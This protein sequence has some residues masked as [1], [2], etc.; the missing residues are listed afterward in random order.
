[1]KELFLARP[2]ETHISEIRAYREECLAHDTHTHGDSGLDEW[3]D[4]S[5]WINSCRMTERK[6]TLP[7][8]G[9]VPAD[10]FMLMEEGRPRII[11][12]D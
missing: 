5:A 6:E 1:M 12:Y 11:R 7:R 4:I 3:E 10:Q 9:L 2:S 8:P